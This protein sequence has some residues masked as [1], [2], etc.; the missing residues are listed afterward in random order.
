MKFKSNGLRFTDAQLKAV[1]Y[2]IGTYVLEHQFQYCNKEC[3]D[4]V[5]NEE[6]VQKAIEELKTLTEE[7]YDALEA[8]DIGNIAFVAN[9]CSNK[10]YADF[11]FNFLKKYKAWVLDNGKADEGLMK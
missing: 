9:M 8:V 1:K 6:H 7:H 5:Q 10:E 4:N 11:C 2:V 3:H